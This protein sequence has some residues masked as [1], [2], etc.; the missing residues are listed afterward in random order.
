M[1]GN[2]NTEREKLEKIPQL[3]E[4]LETV[5]FIKK[6]KKL[7]CLTPFFFHLLKITVISCGNLSTKS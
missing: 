3:Q 2:L 1:L 5:Q 4:I 7:T 6:F